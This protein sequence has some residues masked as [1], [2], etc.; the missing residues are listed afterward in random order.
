M[1]D[2]HVPYG[3]RVTAAREMLAWSQRELARE[4]GV[5]PDVISR[6]ESGQTRTPHPRT[7]RAIHNALKKA[8]VPDDL[9]PPQRLRGPQE[10]PADAPLHHAAHP[11]GVF[12]S[13]LTRMLELVG[14]TTGPD[15]CPLYSSVPDADAEI[16]AGQAGLISVH[17]RRRGYYAIEVPSGDMSPAVPRGSIVVCQTGVARPGSPHACRWRSDDGEECGIRRI[18]ELEDG[19]WCLTRDDHGPP[20]VIDDDALLRADPCIYAYSLG[21]L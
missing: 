21:E 14:D 15:Q 17:A 7:V 3:R 18:Y 6:I 1:T 19:R 10:V 5:A 11:L 2:S 4:A 8:R 12:G 9:V 20:V 13:P 16:A